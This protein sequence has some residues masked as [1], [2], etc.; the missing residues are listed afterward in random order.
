[1]PDWSYRTLFRPLLFRLPARTARDLALEA[2][3]T[4]ARLPG[5]PSIIDFLGH[6]RPD[7]KLRRR[8]GR[9]EVSS[10]VGLGPYLDVHAR[11][12][13]ALGR[14]GVG[15][16]EVG[17]V[18][19]GERTSP[20]A[21]DRD[22]AHQAFRFP[23][24]APS[25]DV[26]VLHRQLIAQPNPAI[27][28]IVRLA[29]VDDVE[30]ARE[31]IRSVVERLRP[32]AAAFSV[33]GPAYHVAECLRCVRELAPEAGRFVVLL[34]DSAAAATA[35]SFASDPPLF[36]GI[37]IDGARIAADGTCVVGEGS[38]SDVL[39]TISSCRTRLDPEL[40]IVAYGGIHSP[41]R[42]L[43]F[44]SA[45]ATCVQIDSGLVFSGP[46]LVKRTNEAIMARAA[47]DSS[48]TER[49]TRDAVPTDA[50]APRRL[51]GKAWFWSFVLGLGMLFGGGLTLAIAATRIILPYD[52]SLI[53]LDRAQ[54][55]DLN[56]NLLPFMRHDRTSLAGAMLAVGVFYAFL[57]VGPLRR[58]AH[59]AHAAITASAVVGFFT[60]FAFLAFGYFDPFHAFVTAILS[61]IFLQA[62]CGDLGRSEPPSVACLDDDRAWRMSQW[63]QLIFLLQGLTLIGAGATILFIGCTYVLVD[64]DLAFLCTTL[65]ELRAAGPHLLPLIAHDRVTFG[66]ML[67]CS[68]ITLTLT[69]LWGFRRGARGLWWMLAVGTL[70]GYVAALVVH[71]HVGYVDQLHLTPTY[72]GIAATSVAA[73]LCR[74]YLC[75]ELPRSA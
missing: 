8:V 34:A 15:F 42:A 2:M 66:G 43:E 70:Q 56:E 72:L 23:G 25:I 39:R 48:F 36:D 47:S 18:V 9:L 4:L 41:R 74:S 12:L 31:A 52:E 11:A 20:D 65:D 29:P 55:R 45:G 50:A 3:G 5:G 60:F 63:G 71:L 67:V 6:M 64:S 1:M 58:G 14:F 35:T 16:I 69:V 28:L 54:I 57:A 27:P 75:A 73:A 22:D 32:F 33:A 40:P 49:S 26:E 7:P 19:V 68:G 61:Q 51:F 44:L 21:V 59:W 17:P 13:A 10:P 53:G 62:L 38:G 46:G 24:G 30:D 37:I